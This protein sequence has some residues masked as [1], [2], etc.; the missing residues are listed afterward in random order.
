VNDI[1]NFEDA[2][3]SFRRFLTQSGHPAEIVWVFREDVWKRSP[4]DVAVRYP[5]SSDNL[6]LIQKVFAEGR[7]RGLLDMHAIAVTPN[8]VAATVWFPR[9]PEDELQGWNR[10]MLLSI[11]EPLPR[12]KLVGRLRWMFYCLV[13]RFRHYQNAELWVGTKSWAAA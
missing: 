12:A 7:E 11:A 6:T 4:T 3:K 5:P 8:S 13:P 10:G 9:S 2:V 1:P